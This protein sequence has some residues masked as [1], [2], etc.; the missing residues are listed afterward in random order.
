LQLVVFKKLQAPALYF[1]AGVFIS[2][3]SW[4]M[5]C[6]VMLLGLSVGYRFSPSFWH[7]FVMFLGYYLYGSQDLIANIPAFFGSKVAGV[8]VLKYAIWITWAL[9]LSLP[10]LVFRKKSHTHFIAAVL[11]VFLP[12]IGIF[13][14]MSPLNSAGHLLPN[15]GFIG[16]I[17][18]LALMSVLA[19]SSILRVIYV[20]AFVLT[21]SLGANLIDWL[22][23]SDKYPA[24]NEVNLSSGATNI[25]ALDTSVPHNGDTS[26]FQDMRNVENIRTTVQTAISGRVLTGATYIILPEEV[27]GAWRTS[28]S[29]LLGQL[30]HEL[31]E[32]KV[33]LV[34]GADQFHSDRHVYDDAAL[35]LLP[36]FKNGVMR[37]SSH[38]VAFAKIPM[39]GGN[40]NFMNLG[41]GNTA[42][43]DIVGVFKPRKSEINGIPVYFSF[44]YEDFLIWPH[45]FSS[46]NNQIWV[47][48]ANNWF[49]T[50]DSLAFHVQE[51]T[52]RS[53]ARLF[54]AK[55]LRSVNKKT[56]VYKK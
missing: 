54:G 40:W 22:V 10:Y 32:K 4:Q 7:T 42:R 6:L 13:G 9:V 23:A 43:L 28:K 19:V 26:S 21:L 2:I 39:P 38:Q 12:P 14:W 18:T 20:S 52:I 55:L 27:I 35:L 56:L 29:Y 30:V 3:A 51:R 16:L 41:N 31:S 8:D 34:I 17:M 33:F 11:V 49:Q 36:V 47:S 48:M 5:G 53:T 15:F 25:F 1:L 45:L 46:Q 44:C 24:H 37:A 50:D